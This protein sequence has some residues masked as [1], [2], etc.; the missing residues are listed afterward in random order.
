MSMEKRKKKLGWGGWRKGA[1][2]KPRPEGTI[3][4]CVSLN[5]QIWHAARRSWTGKAS[6]LVEM[7]V[8]EH[9]KRCASGQNVEALI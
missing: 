8:S 4:I 1:G 6:H 5:K 2:R 7:L 3:K 9:V